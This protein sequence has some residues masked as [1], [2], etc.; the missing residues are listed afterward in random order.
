MPPEKKGRRPE[1]KEPRS[2]GE[3]GIP[4]GHLRRR[5]E[6]ILQGQAPN[7]E[8]LTAEGLQD[9]AHE[10]QVHQIELELQ[11]QALRETQVALE[12]AR[13]EYADLY[14]HAPVG[15]V[16]VGGDGAIA[17]AN[18]TAA[19]LF[20]AASTALVGQPFR[21]FVA[22]DNQDAYHFFLV[23]LSGRSRETSELDLVRGDGS[24]FRARLE[25]VSSG[26][27]P[28]GRP[29]WRVALADVTAEH[30]A[31]EALRLVVEGTAPVIGHD[32]LRA[33]VRHLARL[34]DVCYVVVGEFDDTRSRV[35]TR[36][37]WAGNDWGENWTFDLH[38]TAC[39]PAAAGRATFYASGL[40]RGF[41]GD[42]FVTRWQ[43]DSVRAMPLC[44]VSGRVRGVLLAMDEAPMVEAPHLEPILT[45]SVERAA[46]ELARL[47]TETSLRRFSD[48]QAALYTVA[49]ALATSLEPA[50][51]ANRV[52]DVIVPLFGAA[53]AWIVA[54]GQ[55][56][57]D[58][59]RVVGSRGFGEVDIEPGE[60]AA[61]L[62]AWPAGPDSLEPRVAVHRKRVP[63][64]LLE[65]ANMNGH[66]CLSLASHDQ[67]VG[68]LHLAWYGER[69][70][71]NEEESL[72]LAI[73][74]QVALGLYNARL[75]QQARQVDRLRV[76]AELDLALMASLDPGEVAAIGLE[77]MASA[78]R[79]PEA[80]MLG[81]TAVLN[82]D[83]DPV[84]TLDEGWTQVEASARYR[85]WSDIVE[86]L[87]RPRPDLSGPRPVYATVAPWDSQVLVVPLDDD[88]PLADL[89][90]AGRT[91]AEEDVA[92]ARAAA[93]RVSQALRNARLYAEVRVLLRRQAE[94]QAQLVHSEKMGAL[95]R[96]T[97]SFSHEI[98][99]PLQ[100]VLGCLDLLREE[101]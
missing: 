64:G 34:L 89:L 8:G 62:E 92:L 39:A 83:G 72:L 45:I 54:A 23:R 25:G 95:G 75:Y 96:L 61:E 18:A 87:R 86:T 57:D 97:A 101:L 9:L 42:P 11:N 1:G 36:A 27:D 99:N 66:V 22:R 4:S 68:W 26:V 3:D 52:L 41:P 77:R 90:L 15:Y 91:F 44:D 16:T 6:A 17:R 71:S 85:R 78:V 19:A 94:S 81:Y 20:G 63:G 5:A 32:F 55:A 74:D 40:H 30:E 79:A 10:L 33:L 56:H 82:R 73:G 13:D 80:L 35:R 21:R 7:L 76:L 70:L 100:S 48:E 67:V 69:A 58:P 29:R 37:V 47:E 24:R 50:E 53:A 28:E 14:D 98:N 46:A 38:G 2:G 59:P 88:E 93:S 84:L 60:L 31:R 65:P 49:A 43:V 51:L 12:L